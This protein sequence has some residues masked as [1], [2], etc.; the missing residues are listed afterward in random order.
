MARNLNISI[1]T[2]EACRA[3]LMKKSHVHSTIDLVRW[4]IQERLIPS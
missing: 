3:R 2:V 4:A 1:K